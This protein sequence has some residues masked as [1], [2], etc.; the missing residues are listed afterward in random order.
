MRGV[1]AA[2]VLLASPAA[3][4]REIGAALLGVDARAEPDPLGGIAGDV[5][6]GIEA[7]VT[8][9]RPLCAGARLGFDPDSGGEGTSSVSSIEMPLLVRG[10]WCSPG[11]RAFAFAWLGAGATYASVTTEVA[12][13]SRTDGALI[14]LLG[15]GVDLVLRWRSLAALV[16][17][18]GEVSG[19]RWAAVLRFGL[20]SFGP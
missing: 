11:E 6:F 19:D 7:L 5:G 16:G 2:A 13:V 1:A 17:G 12:G 3:D 8:R 15:A 9:F 10:G 4:A 20:G 14:P 18:S